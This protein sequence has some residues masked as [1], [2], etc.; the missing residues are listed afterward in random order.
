MTIRTL[1]IKTLSI[2]ALGAA[3]IMSA[4]LAG[5][6]FAQDARAQ[7]P[8][9]HRPA[10]ALRHYRGTYNQAAPLYAA[11]APVDGFS[12]QSLPRDHSWVGGVDPSFRPAGT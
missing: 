5:P 1:S 2:K 6:V 7:G 3:A 11:P 10:Y 9:Y 4:A 12:V 8:G